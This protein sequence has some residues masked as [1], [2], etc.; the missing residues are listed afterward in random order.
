[1]IKSHSDTASTLPTGFNLS[2][3][4]FPNYL[5]FI[6]VL[7]NSTVLGHPVGSSRSSC[8]VVVVVGRRWGVGLM[9]PIRKPEMV[10]AVNIQSLFVLENF[11]P[12][13]GD[14]RSNYHATRE[15]T[16][17]PVTMWNFF[18]HQRYFKL[19]FKLVSRVGVTHDR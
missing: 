6:V 11:P 8:N 4:S 1:M 13:E 9:T 5:E 7:E 17:E 15:L 3:I 18:R 2:S 16:S 12:L 14:W 10:S 19:V